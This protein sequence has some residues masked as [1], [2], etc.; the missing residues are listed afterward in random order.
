[1]SFYT[2]YI[3]V[4]KNG[5]QEEQILD[6]SFESSPE[7]EKKVLSNSNVTGVTPRLEA[8]ALASTENITKGCL[9]VGIDPDKENQITMLRN[10]L[11]QGDYVKATDTAILLSIGLSKRL[12][13]GLNDTMV[14]IAQG[15]HGAT[16]GGKFRIKGI[17]EF[18]SPELNDKALF[19]PL[20]AAQD[21]Y[22]APGMVTSYVL[23]LKDTRDPEPTAASVASTLGSNYEVL[24]WG[25]IIPD[26]KQ[27][28]STD[29]GNA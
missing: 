10:K 27:H 15:Y 14:L 23:S 22:S 16:A 8:F 18:G 11:V 28:I 17:L 24:T 5:Y 3:Q 20:A 21:F 19:M 29:T 9:V 12:K 26:I 13:L 1:V 4:H 2:G 25:Q 6:N 7:T